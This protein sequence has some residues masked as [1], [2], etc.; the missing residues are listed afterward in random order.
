MASLFEAMFN[1]THTVNSHAPGRVNL[2]GD[3]TDYNHGF[4]FPAAINY[5]TDV[6][7]SK[8]DDNIVKVCAVT[9]GCQIIEFDMDS[10]E[11]NKD[12]MW[13]NYVSGCMLMLQKSGFLLGGVNLLIN[14]N[15]PQGGGLSSSASLE[16]AILKAMASLFGFCLSGIEA[17]QIGQRVENDFVGCNCG[18]MDQLASAM[19]KTSH[20][21]LLDCQTL[22]IEEAHLPEDWAIMVIN[23]NVKRGLVESEYNLRRQ[24]CELAAKCFQAESL[25]N[26]TLDQLNAASHDI[27]PVLLKR[28][29][30][31]ISENDRVIKTKFAIERGDMKSLGE[32]MFSS[33]DSLKNDFETSVPQIDA[34][35]DILRNA[36]V[37]D[38]S[39]GARMTGG[40]FGGCVV[41][42]VK[43]EKIDYISQLVDDQYPKLTALHAELYICNAVQ[44]AFR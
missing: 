37:P 8:R 4:V 9:F 24:Q 5:G 12:T 16:I 14:G 20:A 27:A 2:I 6:Y 18:I 23:S 7:A 44:G 43:R 40:G 1:V 17:A 36:L 28:A 10:I 39:G 41:A 22:Q 31:V 35:V 42:V 30:H 34:L 32:L 38:H 29:R 3:H 13:S 26:V 19:G 21:I 25:R 33:H 11:F 15:I